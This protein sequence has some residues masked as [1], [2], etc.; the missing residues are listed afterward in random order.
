M[1][2]NGWLNDRHPIYVAWADEWKRE[3]DRFRGGR[4]ILAELARFDWEEPFGE[5]FQARSQQASYLP[6]PAM[7]SEVMTGH[8][9]RRAPDVGSGLSFG[10]LGKVNTEAAEVTRADLVY[11]NVDGA[12]REGS[13]WNAWWMEVTRWTPVTGHRW[14]LTE[15][16]RTKPATLEDEARG[17]HPYLVHLSPLE[18]INWHY[19]LGVLQFA[20]V[21]TYERRPR[22]VNGAW[23]GAAESPVYYLLVA[24]RFDGLG[25]EYEGGGWWLFD[26][27]GEPLERNGAPASGRWESTKGEVPLFPYFYQRDL[28]SGSDPE[29]FAFVRGADPAPGLVPATRSAD[30]GLR[31]RG[32]IPLSRPSFSRPGL[33]GLGQVAVSYMNLS[34]AADYDAWDAASSTH[35]VLGASVESFN[36]AVAKWKEGNRFVPFPPAPDGSIPTITDGSAGAVAAEVFRARLEHKAWEARFLSFIEATSDPGSSGESKRMGFMDSKAPRLAAMAQEAEAA[37]GNALRLL[38]LRWGIPTPT[39]EVKWVKDFDLRDLLSDIDEMFDLMDRAALKS[40]TLASSM[41]VASARQRGLLSDEAPEPTVRKEFEEAAR[42]GA[43]AAAARRDLLAELRASGTDDR[44][45]EDDE[46]P[47][48]EDDAGEEEAGS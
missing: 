1:K 28:S 23:E 29:A 22:L 12:G 26:A 19:D 35:F 48:L 21:K 10:G 41:L 30:R 17:L 38:E 34:S 44:V 32:V 7:H 27:D 2:K 5:H 18:V 36:T 4:E 25:P 20:V 15:A 40:P 37:Q 14:I 46:E 9:F 13:S 6:F 39:S 47:A 45:E 16:P 33:T 24:D 43:E 3:E 8:L 11:Y 31:A 42:A